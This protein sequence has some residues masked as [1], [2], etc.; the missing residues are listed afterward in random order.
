MKLV[1]FATAMV[2][3]MSACMTRD[4][5]QSRQGS[6]FSR[7]RYGVEVAPDKASAEGTD[8]TTNRPVRNARRPISDAY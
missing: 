6:S 3:L 4:N 1:V 7:A 2:G 8:R 5:V